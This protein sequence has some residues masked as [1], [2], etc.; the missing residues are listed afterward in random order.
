MALSDYFEKLSDAMDSYFGG[1]DGID[2]GII[3]LIWTGLLI[4]TIIGQVIYIPLNRNLTRRQELEDA[5]PDVLSGLAE[6]LRAGMSVEMA[7]DAVANQRND[8]MGKM[9][10]GVVAEMHN[11]SFTDAMREFADDSGSPMIK[12]V[13][14]ILNV[15]LVSSGS[16]SETLEHLSEEFW[17]IY[18]MRKERF[19]KTSGSANFILWGGSLVCPLLLGLI[20]SVFGSGKAGSFELDIDLTLLNQA[21]VGY[22]LVL[23]TAGVFMQS[24]IVQRLRTAILRMPLFMFIAITTLL[25]SLK[26]SIV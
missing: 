2:A 20:V 16:F 6:S 15:A 18:I 23:G 17:E 4:W 22:M 21:L 11:S 9:L 26:I 12:R 24:I 5:W 10:R 1:N 14:G 13:V 3:A 7:L 19:A 25:L 8:R